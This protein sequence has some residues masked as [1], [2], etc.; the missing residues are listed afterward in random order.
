MV[1][2]TALLRLAPLLAAASAQQLQY[3]LKDHFDQS[4]FFT[5]FNFFSDRDPTNGFV[6]YA[7][8]QTA[9]SAQL[10]GYADGMVYLGVDFRDPSPAG[11]RASVRV[12]SNA[13]Y[14][15]G[16][17]VADIAHMPVGCG[18]WPAFW[19]FGPNWPNS[20][21]V[22]II[23]GVNSMDTT[24][25][26]LHTGPGCSVRAEGGLPDTVLKE[27]NC[28][29]DEGRGGCGQTTTN[30]A[31][32]GA[33]FN[34]NGGGVYAMEWTPQ[35]ISVWFFPRGSPQ[36]AAT[37]ANA[38]APPDMASWGPPT[39]R[40]VGCDF[41]QHFRAHNIVF[42]TALCGD[43]AGKQEVWAADATCSAAAPTCR[44]FVTANPGA[45]AEAYW[46]I[47][48]VTVFEAGAAPGAGKR[49]VAFE[50]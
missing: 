11:G 17:F 48:S 15:R 3:A 50:A 36:A 45:F 14:T 18:V 34:A 9:N 5:G 31:G 32:F 46:L 4:N 24:L 20:G 33:G 29:K 38:T 23:E 21:E 16:L 8:A 12:S 6:R 19:T 42:N 47:K 40:F 1:R 37:A 41:D 43:W 25:I 30:R 13:A 26:T 22:D 28:N 27:T 44:D 39:A 49:G 35:S 2:T 7:A 10:A